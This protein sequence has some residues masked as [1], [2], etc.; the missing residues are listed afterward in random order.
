MFTRVTEGRASYGRKVSHL[1]GFITLAGATVVLK[2]LHFGYKV[3]NRTAKGL[4]NLSI[5]LFNL[6]SSIIYVTYYLI[7]E[8]GYNI[9][10]IKG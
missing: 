7:E 10:K 5:Y 1:I 6:Q 9:S 3:H 2:V 8:Y 4:I